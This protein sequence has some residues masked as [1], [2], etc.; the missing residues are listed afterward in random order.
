MIVM[1]VLAVVGM[2]TA[3]TF[4]PPAEGPIAFRR[5]RVPL[6][7]DQMR[8]LS[9]D[10]M[11]LASGMKGADPQ[12]RRAVA[13][14]LALA[15]ALNPAN[16]KARSLL[17]RWQ[18]GTVVPEEI[19]SQKQA[20]VGRLLPVL[21]WLG[22]EYAGDDGWALGDCLSD[23]LGPMDLDDPSLEKWRR[24]SEVG[25]WDGWVP[26]LVAYGYEQPKPVAPEVLVEEPTEHEPPLPLTADFQLKLRN[27]LI[28]T[29]IWRMAGTRDEDGWEFGLSPL[30]VSAEMEED[31][32]FRLKLGGP[33]NQGSLRSLERRVERALKD[34]HGALPKGLSLAITSDAFEK[35]LESKKDLSISAPLAVLASAVLIGRDPVAMVIGSLNED[36]TLASGRNFWFKLKAVNDSVG[37]RVVVPTEVMPLLRAMLTSGEPGFFLTN[38]VM[39]ADSYG[40]L[41]KRALGGG[42]GAVVSASE[43]FKVIQEY[44]KDQDIQRYLANSHVRARLEEVVKE[45]P[46]HASAQLLLILGNEAQSPWLPKE[47]VLAELSKMLQPASRIKAISYSDQYQTGYTP[48]PAAEA[49]AVLGNGVERLEKWIET[50]DQLW[51]D[52]ARLV[53]DKLRELDRANLIRNTYEKRTAVMNSSLQL[54]DKCRMLVRDIERELR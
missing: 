51:L 22:T 26:D 7:A 28:V 36:G 17:K 10:L 9:S 16:T 45:D 31:A 30:M 34:Q 29:P 54:H 46:G 32:P 5:D 21:E 12:G 3:S 4:A 19:S 25:R 44:A 52:R 27:A 47:V 35:S 49:A 33:S 8:R 2:A 24:Q 53:L 48:P 37:G 23:L 41:L 6:A 1:V 40:D 18:K 50:T 20:V 14:T 39:V 38:E 11:V 43:K 15:L 13:Q 42:S